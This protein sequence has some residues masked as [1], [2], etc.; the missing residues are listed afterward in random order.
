M[1]TGRARAADFGPALAEPGCRCLRIAPI[2]RADAC[3]Q[4][5]AYPYGRASVEWA[6]TDGVLTVS[7]LVPPNT[8]TEVALPDGP[9]PDVGP[10]LPGGWRPA[11][12]GARGADGGG[13]WRWPAC[14]AGG[15]VTEAGSDATPP[16]TRGLQS[17]TCP[18]REQRVLRVIGHVGT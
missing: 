9:R 16:A 8:T 10:G 7:A 5:A 3:A 12:R 17:Q 11:L 6:V 18:V 15:L 4:R 13:E 14:T 2:P 1:R